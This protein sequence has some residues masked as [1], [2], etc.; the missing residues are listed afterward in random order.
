MQGPIPGNSYGADPLTFVDGTGAFSTLTDVA[1]IVVVKLEW[2]AGAGGEDIISL[3]RFLEGETMSEAAFD[4]Q[5]LAMPNLTSANWATQPSL[6]QSQF[7]TITFAGI[8]YF[9]DEIRLG[10][11]FADVTPIPEPMT[12]ALLGLGGLGL[13]RRRRRA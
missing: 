12:L 2:D 13:I 9:V 10:E 8:K 6:D 5:I 11:T 7:D 3:G 4:A 1:N